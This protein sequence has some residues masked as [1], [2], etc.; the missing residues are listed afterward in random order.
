M[1][2]DLLWTALHHWAVFLLVG[3]L[4]AEWALLGLQPT[5]AWVRRLA[6]VDTLYGAASGLVL[7]AGGARLMWGAKGAAFY[8]SNPVF[9]AKM[10]VFALIGALSIYP[11]VNYL[12]WRKAA[13]QSQALPD[14]AR[15]QS[16]RRW[17]A[18]ELV[19]LPTLPVLAAMMARGVG[20]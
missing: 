10:G 8:M 3:A 16:V 13:L 7:L 14:A 4:V 1:T 6:W 5:V 18:A 11:T 19:L 12:R 20:L 9:W 15:V 17:V 2:N